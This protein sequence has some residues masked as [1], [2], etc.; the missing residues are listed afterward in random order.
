[1]TR[2]GVY[3]A[4]RPEQGGTFQ[5]NL[6]ILAGL[7][8][9]TAAGYEVVA[10]TSSDLWLE[11]LAQQ[12]LTAVRLRSGP[13]SR[14]SAALW[15]RLGLPVRGWR[16][17]SRWAHPLTRDILRTKCAVWLFPSQDPWTYRLP[18]RSIGTV[19][20]L[21]HRYESRFP[22]VSEGR[23]F[24]KR[25]RNF[26]GICRWSAGVLVDS[27]VGR[28]QL[29]ESYAIK[30]EKVHVLPYVAPDYVREAPPDIDIRAKFALPDKFFFYPAQFWEHKNHALIVRA[31]ARLGE[32]IGDLAFVLAGG[33]KNAYD[34]FVRKVN[35][36]A[37]GERF[38]VLGYV[39]EPDLTLLYRAARALVMP[40]FFG[41]TNI[42]PLEAFALGCPVA[43]SRVYGMPGQVGDA[44]ILFD[45]CDLD[46]LTDVLRRLWCDDDLCDLLRRRGLQ[47]AQEWGPIQFGSALREILDRV[48]E[49]EGV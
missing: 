46:E 35:K 43:V 21:M 5:Y 48:L 45:P 39:D 16:V 38:H 34:A 2:V 23:L 29:I 40:T 20:D 31:V 42:P 32:E 26:A 36:H 10:A 27:D 37:L 44:A 28:E 25:E 1:M 8:S 6:T 12:G 47:R 41:P 15:F 3:L 49:S 14:A 7:R 30:H 13:W 18:V 22:E 19:H 9:L 17:L 4:G 24:C 33:R 11:R